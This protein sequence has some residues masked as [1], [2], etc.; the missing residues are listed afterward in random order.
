MAITANIAVFILYL[1]RYTEQ[2]MTV[3]DCIMDYASRHNILTSDGLAAEYGIKLATTRQYLSRLAASGEL[4]RIGYGQYAL[5]TVKEKFP[6]NVPQNVV[7]LYNE[8][9]TSLPFADFCVYSGGVYEPLQHHISINRAIYVETNKDTVDSVF[10]LLKEK[11]GSVY[12]QPREKFMR[13][14]V[15]LRTDCIIVKTL[16]TEAPVTEISGVPSP[17]LEKILVDILKDSDLEYLRG[18]EFRYMFDTAIADFRISKSKLLRY[19]RRRGVYDTVQTM[20]NAFPD[21]KHD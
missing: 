4:T 14:Y 7:A 9:R 15:D 3:A 19:A 12:R 8:L 6:V 17:S 13:D 1:H 18:M 10:S 5:S 11:Y 21:Y 2:S 20:L 16:V